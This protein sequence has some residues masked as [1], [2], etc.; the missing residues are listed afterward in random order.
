MRAPKAASPVLR[1]LTLPIRFSTLNVAKSNTV[2]TMGTRAFVAR[3]G[4]RDTPIGQEEWAEAVQD[5]T[6][7]EMHRW[8]DGELTALLRGSRRRRVTWHDGYLAAHHTDARMAAAVFALAERLQA[9]VYSEHRQRFASLADWHQRVGP[10]D[11][12]RTG[13]VL[14]VSPAPG[15][16]SAAWLAWVAVA[17]GLA[18]LMI[19]D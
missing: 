19:A 11:R 12:H 4:W 9:D 1:G 8:P 10:A 7:L 5:S 14:A 6:D 3:P 16:N 13:R 17:V 2:T 18:F 15:T